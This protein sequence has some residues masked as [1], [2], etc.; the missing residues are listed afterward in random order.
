[1]LSKKIADYVSF[2]IPGLCY[3]PT[4]IKTKYFTLVAKSNEINAYKWGNWPSKSA[5]MFHLRKRE[6]ILIN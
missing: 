2:G 1:M 4:Q 5:F 6:A 3:F